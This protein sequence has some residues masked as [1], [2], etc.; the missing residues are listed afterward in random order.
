M[1]NLDFFREKA[2]KWPGFSRLRF[3]RC[4]GFFCPVFAGGKVF[5]K[6]FVWSILPDSGL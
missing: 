1:T 6:S 3:S 2:Y 5:A 4:A